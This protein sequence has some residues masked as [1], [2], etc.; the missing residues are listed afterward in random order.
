MKIKSS[1]CNKTNF[2][3]WLLNLVKSLIQCSIYY[4]QI[5]GYFTGKLWDE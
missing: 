1:K 5:T 3:L 4:M 2:T